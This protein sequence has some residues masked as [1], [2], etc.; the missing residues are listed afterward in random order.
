MK[1]FIIFDAHPS[2]VQAGEAI[3]ISKAC[4]LERWLLFVKDDADMGVFDG[5]EILTAAQVR[6][7]VDST[8]WRGE[9]PV[10][11]ADLIPSLA[12]EGSA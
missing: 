9:D 10:P 4:F 7:A 6:A 12:D 5:L 8:D 1:R 2:R 11:W 3:T